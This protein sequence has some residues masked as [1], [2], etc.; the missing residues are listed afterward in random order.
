MVF[1]RLND[2]ARALLDI[3]PGM[4]NPPPGYVTHIRVDR[5]RGVGDWLRDR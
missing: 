3:F 1:E 2:A 4:P 5:I